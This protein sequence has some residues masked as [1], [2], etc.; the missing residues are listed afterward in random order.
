[1]WSRGKPGSSFRPHED[2]LFNAIKMLIAQPQRLQEMGQA[3]RDYVQ[4]RSFG[5]AFQASWKMYEEKANS[6]QFSAS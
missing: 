1:M 2:S 3:A 6:Y 5:A 4:Q